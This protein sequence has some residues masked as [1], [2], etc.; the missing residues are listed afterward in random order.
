MIHVRVLGLRQS[1]GLMRETS[2]WRPGL[3]RENPIVFRG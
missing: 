2:G 3:T 1:G